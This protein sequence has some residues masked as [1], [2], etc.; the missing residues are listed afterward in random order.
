MNTPALT[1]RDRALMAEARIAELEAEVAAWREY[2]H[3]DPKSSREEADT[4]LVAKLQRRLRA[5]TGMNDTRGVAKT[6]LVLLAHPGRLCRRSTIFDAV[7]TDD[8]TDPKVI[9]VR[10]SRTRLL[11]RAI[12]Y[13]EAI[14]TVWGEGYVLAAESA[15]DIRRTLGL[16]GGEA[17]AG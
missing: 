4:L 12:G 14:T 6:L 2:G 8:T 15:G 5:L 1:Y 13:P 17:R 3:T 16:P 11:L 9:D 7:T 10:V